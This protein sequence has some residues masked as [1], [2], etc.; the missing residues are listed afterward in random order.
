MP[1][2]VQYS[3]YI[4]GRLA[5]P[6]QKRP[7]KQPH[8]H[9]HHH[10]TKDGIGHSINFRRQELVIYLSLTTELRLLFCRGTFRIELRTLYL[11]TSMQINLN[12]KSVGMII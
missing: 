12:H 3:I 4:Q 9:Q 7:D 10:P 8:T 5:S 1:Y 2:K 11:N 6:T